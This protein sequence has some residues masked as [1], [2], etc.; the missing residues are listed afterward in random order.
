MATQTA[1]WLAKETSKMH[2]H[3]T[4]PYVAATAP[5]QGMGKI[6]AAGGGADAA[7]RDEFSQTAV[8]VGA[9]PP[10][11]RQASVPAAAPVMSRR[12]MKRLEREQ[13]RLATGVAPVSHSAAALISAAPAASALKQ[14]TDSP[15]VVVEAAVIV[16]PQ[17]WQHHHAELHKQPSLFAQQFQLPKEQS[18]ERYQAAEDLTRFFKTAGQQQRIWG[19]DSS[20][21]AP[22]ASLRPSASSAP[23]T[24]ATDSRVSSAAPAY[25]RLQ[26]TVLPVP[27][28]H[29]LWAARGGVWGAMG[30]LG[31]S[32]AG[33]N[34]SGKGGMMFVGDKQVESRPPAEDALWS[35]FGSGAGMFSSALNARYCCT[36]RLT[37]LLQILDF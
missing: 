8:A 18:S 15:V 29:D 5:V 12:A 31:S 4:P 14:E 13:R 10:E 7:K 11:F 28:T 2:L 36:C 27:E 3:P 23:S 25:T 6:F 37:L 9:W 22:A 16:G 1:G 24:S 19:H 34:S 30:D 33:S 17:Q 21:D 32:S 20:C 35:G 26:P